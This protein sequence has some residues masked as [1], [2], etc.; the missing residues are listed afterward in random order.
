[1]KTTTS[2]VVLGANVPLTNVDVL[3]GSNEKAADNTP[4]VSKWKL[5]IIC[6]VLCLVN[7]LNNLDSIIVATAIPRITDEFDS[8]NDI[9][10][11]GTMYVLAICA[12]QLP[13]GKLYQLCESKTV[14]LSALF[15]FEIGSTVCGSARSSTMLIIGRLIAGFG[16]AGLMNG[17]LTILSALIPLDRRP[18][19]TGLVVGLSLTGLVLGPLIGG[20]LTEHASWRWCFYINLPVGAIAFASLVFIRV[21]NGQR[22][23]SKSMTIS[24][25]MIRLDLVGCV[26]FAGS[27]AMLI[28]ALQEGGVNYTWGH[29]RIVMLIVGSSFGFLCFFPCWQHYRGENAMLPLRILKIRI[30]ACTVVANTMMS[31]AAYSSGYY[32]PIWFQVVKNASPTTS[33]VYTLPNIISQMLA[34][35]I[36]GSLV[37]WSGQSTLFMIGG[38]AVMLTGTGLYT[39]LNMNSV[40]AAFAGFQIIQGIGRGM[41]VLQPVTTIQA[42]LSKE[43]EPIGSAM[44]IFT[45]NF[46]PAIFIALGQTVLQ[47][48]LGGA[49][50]QYAPTV[51]A[52]KVI[53]VGATNFRDVVDLSQVESVMAAYNAAIIPTFVSGPY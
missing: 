44:T 16:A 38:V 20:A 40:V 39:I 29:Y 48:Q 26:L 4:Q 25:K 53:N 42:N 46:G 32:L 41:S 6:T 2:K 14:F 31:G 27:T 1:M 33:G 3:S 50:R 18:R 11:Y 43:D 7:F 19:L 47:N 13:F 9:G 30:V 28:V 35:I 15:I 36:T 22:E 52:E 23:D 37:S 24:Q 21:P 17:M 49:L 51:D 12:I 5:T 10:W 8:L 34:T 45:M